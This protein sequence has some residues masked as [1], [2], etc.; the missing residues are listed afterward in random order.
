[1]KQ[2]IREKLDFLSSRLAELDRELSSEDAARDMD[3]FRTLGRERAEIEPVVALYEAWRRTESDAASAREMLADA[4][5]RELVEMEL[6]TC[7]ERIAALEDELQRALLPRDPDDERNL[8]LEVRAGT[9]GDEAA[10]FAGDLLR[11]YTRYAERQRWK[12]EIV[13]ASESDLGGYKEVIARVIGAGAYSKLKFESGG[14]RVQR[15]PA[16]ETQGRIHTSA[17][18]VAV[19]PEADEL[20]AVNINPADLRI[21]TFR[22]S[23]AGGQHINK[24]DSAVR[25]TH[26]PTG[27]VVECQ[28]DRSQHRNKAQAMSVL[29]AR[30]HD[31]QLREQQARE[32]ATRKSL[33]GSGDRSERIRT[34]N[35]P[36]GRVTDHRINLTLYKLDAVMEGELDELVGALTAEHQAAQL[37]ALAGE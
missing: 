31:I 13:S 22:A 14:H 23:G 1:M 8:F 6:A 2:S 30:I 7:A 29:A 26:L 35:F 16:T 27:I 9:G 36:Q 15:V 33:V 18:T 17:C 25:I 28:D 19:M 11:M 32:A 21:D 34:Y 4:E 10:L 24:T 20:E 3:A 37:A 12:V 5:M